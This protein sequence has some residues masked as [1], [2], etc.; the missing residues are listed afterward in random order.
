MLLIGVSVA[1]GGPIP[2][3]YPSD[4]P[5]NG[6]V[7]YKK[8]GTGATQVELAQG[9]VPLPQVEMHPKGVAIGAAQGVIQVGPS[10][11]GHRCQDEPHV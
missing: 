10:E 5:A 2:H 11:E 8:G 3:H 6:M 4:E 7:N 1:A 9:V